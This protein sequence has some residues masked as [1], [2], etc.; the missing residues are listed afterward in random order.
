MNYYR[1]SLIC[2]TILYFKRVHIAFPVQQNKELDN[3]V[4]VSHGSFCS[5]EW[6]LR[7]GKELVIQKQLKSDSLWTRNAISR[8][9]P[10]FITH[11]QICGS[12][13][14]LFHASQVL[15][16]YLYTASIISHYHNLID[17]CFLPCIVRSQVQRTYPVHLV[18]PST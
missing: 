11:I 2:E 7:I 14:A 17:F 3:Y 13:L 18:I 8:T 5:T 16:S 1:F 15:C 12:V 6:F 10:S 4:K 9:T